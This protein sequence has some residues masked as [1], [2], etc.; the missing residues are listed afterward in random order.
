M[1]ILSRHRLISVCLALA[2]TT[3]TGCDRQRVE[4]LEREVAALKQAL[5]EQQKELQA[6][7]DA[8]GDLLDAGETVTLKPTNQRYDAIWHDLG[9]FAIELIDVTPTDAGSRVRL[10]VGNVMSGAVNNV[11]AKIEWGQDPDETPAPYSD[12]RSL[13]RVLPQGAWSELSLDLDDVPPPQLGYIRI[14]ELTIGSVSLRQPVV[15]PA[16]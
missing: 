7:R 12:R 2:G 10:R 3:S 8:V 6:E 1:S 9:V 13:G 4:T 11:E 14:S 16:R 15:K 5:D